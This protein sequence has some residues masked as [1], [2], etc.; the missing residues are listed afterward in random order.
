MLKLLA[1]KVQQDG[2]RVAAAADRAFEALSTSLLA[3]YCQLGRVGRVA[4]A[5]SFSF[6]SEIPSNVPVCSQGHLATPDS[7]SCTALRSAIVGLVGVAG[8]HERVQPRQKKLGLNAVCFPNQ[9]YLEGFYVAIS[10]LS[11]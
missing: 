1:V 4:A 5:E 9:L 8:K 11:V 10:R 2:G 3:R 6:R 7:N